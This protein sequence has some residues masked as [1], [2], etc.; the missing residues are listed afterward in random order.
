M[1]I[2][3]R[4]FC[5]SILH[6]HSF[7]HLIQKYMLNVYCGPRY[8]TR[9]CTVAEEWTQSWYSTWALYPS[10]EYNQLASVSKYIVCQMKMNVG[11]NRMVRGKED[12]LR[13]AN[14]MGWS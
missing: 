6:S 9:C 10:M 14:D 5:S 4:L 12:V 8:Y 1:K 11:E 13:G 2:I 3:Y 7:V